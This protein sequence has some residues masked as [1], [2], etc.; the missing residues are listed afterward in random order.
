VIFYNFLGCKPN[1]KE[2]YLNYLP[3]FRLIL[4]FDIERFLTMTKADEKESSYKE[5]EALS[6]LNQA[7]LDEFFS[8]IA[9][10]ATRLTKEDSCDKN[11]N[12]SD[13][14]EG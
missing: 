8:I 9:C 10:I 13:K 14:R 3:V 7:L 12:D 1:E 2:R 6:S 4:D 11:D 5:Y